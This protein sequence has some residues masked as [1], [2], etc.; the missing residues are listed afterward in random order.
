MLPPTFSAGTRNFVWCAA[1][2]DALA[3]PARARMA[4]DAEVR[5][6][7]A[8]RPARRAA[9]AAAFTAPPCAHAAPRASPLSTRRDHPRRQVHALQCERLL[10][11]R[12]RLYAAPTSGTCALLHVLGTLDA[13][14]VMYGALSTDMLGARALGRR[15][16]GRRSSGRASA[17]R[18]RRVAHFRRRRAAAR[19]GRD[20]RDARLRSPSRVAPACPRR[21]TSRR[22]R[23]SAPPA[24]TRLSRRRPEAEAAARARRRPAA[25]TRRARTRGGARACRCVA[26]RC[27]QIRI[28]SAHAH[29]SVV[30]LHKCPCVRR[31]LVVAGARCTSTR[32]PSSPPAA[33]SRCAVGSAHSPGARRRGRDVHGREARTLTAL[34]IAVGAHAGCIR[35]DRVGFSLHRV[36][37]EV[38]AR[39]STS[40]AARPRR[41]DAALA[42]LCASRSLTP[43]RPTS[44]A[45]AGARRADRDHGRRADDEVPTRGR[46]LTYA[47]V[48]TS[49]STDAVE[50]G[51]PTEGFALDEDFALDVGLVGLAV[52]PHRALS[53]RRRRGARRARSAAR[54]RCVSR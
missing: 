40:P 54:R 28:S 26:P 38:R 3:P 39:A 49:L 31:L 9:A 25:E 32:P 5:A 7:R 53:A 4:P 24:T 16:D 23:A 33:G 45:G 46:A 1:P 37:E 12:A 21:R 18:G 43:R 6:R 30:G 2:R 14:G 35:F 41:V 17:P 27:R 15:V 44:S 50:A 11:R 10:D 20:G 8:D 19:D 13:L 29:P 42:P 47:P 34:A 22:R 48:E 36:G 51:E 52:A